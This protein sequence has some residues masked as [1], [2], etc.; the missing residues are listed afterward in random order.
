MGKAGK[1]SDFFSFKELFLANSIKID[2]LTQLLIEA[3][4]TTEERFFQNL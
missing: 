4:M 3:G 2:S 1:Q